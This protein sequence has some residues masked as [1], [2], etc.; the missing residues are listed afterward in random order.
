MTVLWNDEEVRGWGMAVGGRAQVFR[1]ERD[2]EVAD[3][4]AQVR[5]AG[6]TVALRGA[7]CS[8]GDAAINGGGHVLDLT[9]MNRIRAFD[10]ERGIARVEPVV[11]IRDLWLHSIGYWFLPSV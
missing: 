3:A 11:T 10:P 2:E 8:Y 1:P 6:G 7:G 9:R 5:G 4:F